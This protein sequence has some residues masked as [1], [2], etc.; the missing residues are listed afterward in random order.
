M[1]AEDWLARL[2]AVVAR[3]NSV[4]VEFARG[5]KAAPGWH[6]IWRSNTAGK[7]HRGSDLIAGQWSAPT[8]AE[9]A[10]AA[11]LALEAHEVYLTR[12]QASE[13]LRD[14]AN[15]PTTGFGYVDDDVAHWREDAQRMAGELCVWCDTYVAAHRVQT[16]VVT[17]DLPDDVYGTQVGIIDS[18]QSQPTINGAS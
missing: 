5:A 12:R 10:E 17:P 15:L 2:D 4:P 18:A 13:T 3:N 11:C 7:L 8:L 6:A 14:L 1:T 16:V 9:V